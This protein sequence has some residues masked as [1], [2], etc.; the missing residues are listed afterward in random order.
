MALAGRRAGRARPTRG[1]RPSAACGTAGAGADRG[2]RRLRLVSD[3]SQAALRH[4]RRHG[5]GADGIQRQRDRVDQAADD[6]VQRIGRAAE[7]DQDRGHQRHRSLAGGGGHLVLDERQGASLHAE[8]R[9]AGRRR[10]LGA[11]CQKRPARP[12]GAA[13]ELPVQVPKPAVFR[14]HHREPVLS[15]SARP[16]PEEARRER[17]VQPS[18]G[19]RAVR[20]ARVAQRGQGRGVSG[21]DPGQPSLH[22]RL[23]QVQARRLHP[24]G[25]AR[26]AARRHADDRS[27]RQ[28]RARRARRQRHGRSARDGRH[29]S[30]PDEPALLRRAHGRRR[31][32]AVRARADPVREELVAGRGARLRRQAVGARVAGPPSPAAEGRPGALRLARRQ[33]DWRRHPVESARS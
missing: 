8:E 11:V 22:G 28:G 29:H 33:R 26:H 17:G 4:L 16:Q 12:P 6:R 1:C 19:R 10:V 3:P 24:L 7:A 27:R 2:R 18:R 5:A 20:I 31:Q 23:R 21:P 14:A 32:R 25:R 13:R 30:G 9:L 15:G